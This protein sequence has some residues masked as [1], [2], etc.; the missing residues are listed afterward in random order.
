MK[1]KFRSSFII[2]IMFLIINSSM[3]IASNAEWEKQKNQPIVQIANSYPI[4]NK[5]QTIL[6]EVN[7]EILED[8][9]INLVSFSPRYTGTTGCEMTAAYIHQ[10]FENNGLQTRYQ[11]W[12]SFGNRYHPKFFSS[13]NVEATHPGTQTNHI[14]LFGAHYDTVQ[15]TPGA[16][17]DGSG[18]AAVLAAAYIL[19]KY[20]F[21]HTLKFVTF[22]GEE[23]GLKGSGAYA[24]EAYQNNNNILFMF[25]ADM[26][27]RATTKEGGRNM[28]FSITEDAFWVMDIF[29]SINFS[30]N[31]QTTFN[32]YT[33]N[34]DGTGHSDYFPFAT[35]GWET[36]AC[37]QGEGDPNMHT[38]Q[39]GLDNVNFSY[40]VKTTKCIIG[41]LAY[42]ADATDIYPQ[43]SIETPK[44]ESIYNHGMKIGCTSQL[45]SLI[46]NEF[47]VHAINNHDEIFPIERVEFYFDNILEYTDTAPPFKWYCNK[48]SCGPHRITIIAYDH[49]GQKTT[50]YID[51]MY[52]NL[53]SK[54]Y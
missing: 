19:S 17:D 35:Y 12:S 14:I 5:I 9:L 43:I 11:E 47:S 24:K 33:I 28:G 39:D 4:T 51:I 45:T 36:V 38:E 50:N 29:Q 49:I 13:Q 37:W 53:R 26:I 44:R 2:L 42:L 46:F 30:L 7:E 31:L 16:N 21:N 41:T 1:K 6:N 25:N 3:S 52:I 20:S 54:L 34:R 40:L 15:Q 10:Q 48:W 22:S 23:I 18:T 27:G 32:Q 8:F